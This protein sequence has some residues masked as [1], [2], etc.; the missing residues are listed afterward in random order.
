MR[1][2][3][4]PLRGEV[5][6]D[7]YGG[8]PGDAHRSGALNRADYPTGVAQAGDSAV[9]PHFLRCVQPVLLGMMPQQQQMWSMENA[10]VRFH[11]IS[12][13]FINPVP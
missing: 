2:A 11:F 12:I 5:A 1:A 9:A 13:K 3:A 10:G 7:G 8:A 4:E 6:V